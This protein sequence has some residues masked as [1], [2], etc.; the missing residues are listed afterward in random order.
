MYPWYLLAK[1]QHVS[2]NLPEILQGHRKDIN[3]SSPYHLWISQ[4][5][6]K[7][8]LVVAVPT[9]SSFPLPSSACPH[10]RGAKGMPPPSPCTTVCRPTQV[11]IQENS[12]GDLRSNVWNG[13]TSNTLLMLLPLHNRAEIAPLLSPHTCYCKIIPRPVFF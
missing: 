13:T 4:A 5:G 3:Q 6:Y 10:V 1:L 9:G 7:Q 12:H 2:E 8:Y 11:Y